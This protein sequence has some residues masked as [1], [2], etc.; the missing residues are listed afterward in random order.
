MQEVQLQFSV[1]DLI[2]KSLEMPTDSVITNWSLMV[3]NCLCLW[4][5]VEL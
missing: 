1:L 5:D 3:A 4:S 2:K